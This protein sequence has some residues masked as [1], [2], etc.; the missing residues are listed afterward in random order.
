MELGV[1]LFHCVNQNNRTDQKFTTNEENNNKM[2][3]KH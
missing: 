3:Q 1:A 2:A